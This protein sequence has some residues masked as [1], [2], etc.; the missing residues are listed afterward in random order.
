MKIQR[1][2]YDIIVGALGFLVLAGTGI[3]LAITW[4]NI[5]AQVPGH[6]NAAGRVDSMTGKGS[7]LFEFIFGWVMFGMMWVVEQFPRIWNTGVKV[8]PANQWRVYRVLKNMLVTMRFLLAVIFSYI[9]VCMA[10]SCQNLP[11]CFMFLLLAGVFGDIIFSCV[12]LVR[13]SR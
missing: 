12:M 10:V 13:V 4:K 6:Y 5:P 2:K 7:I 9:A 8:T 3:Y 1:T 11:G